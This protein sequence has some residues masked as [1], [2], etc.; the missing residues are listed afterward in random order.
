MS[1][2]LLDV[3]QNPYA[4]QL[5]KGLGLPLPLPEKLRRAKGPWTAT[6]LFDLDV[7]VGATSGA[8]L[9]G[10][11]ADTPRSP[12]SLVSRRLLLSSTT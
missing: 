6:P 4:K 7:A 12:R 9:L 3:S 11:L 5:V 8:A 10:A 1:D 2:W